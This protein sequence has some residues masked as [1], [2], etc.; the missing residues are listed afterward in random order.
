MRVCIIIFF[1]LNLISFLV[2][3]FRTGQSTLESHKKGYRPDKVKMLKMAN[4]LRK[5]KAKNKIVKLRN[6]NKIKMNETV[7]LLI[8]LTL[9]T[10]TYYFE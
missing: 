7:S 6:R 8:L 1:A 5:Q 3:I 4:F 9:T 2:L 10:Y